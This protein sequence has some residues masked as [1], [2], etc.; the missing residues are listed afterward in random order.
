M[1]LHI[2]SEDRQEIFLEL[3]FLKGRFYLAGG[4]GLALQIGHRDSID[5][6]F[7]SEKIFDEDK[8]LAELL[9]KLPEHKIISTQKDKGTLSVIIDGSIRASFFYYKYRLIAPLVKEYGFADIASVEDIGVMKCSAITGRASN[10]DYV[11]LYFIL[12][13]ITLKK[14]LS[15]TK[16]KL[17]SLDENLILKSMVYFE[18]VNEDKLLFMPGF[19][20]SFSEVKKF[21]EKEVRNYTLAVIH[22]T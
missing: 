20:I 7:F 16:A 8:L 13:K 12:R 6:D 11:D 3:S 1:N 18:D 5:F 15:F 21:L 4:T 10:K 22:S 9:E 19:E 2:L 14:L 17:I